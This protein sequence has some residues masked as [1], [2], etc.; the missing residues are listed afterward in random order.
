MSVLASSGWLRIAVV[1]L[2]APYLALVSLPGDW[3]WLQW[4]AYVPALLVVLHA[5]PREL[6]LLSWLFGAVSLM[7]LFRW[8]APT[9]TIYLDIA[10][11]YSTAV[12]VA[13]GTFCGLPHAVLWSAAPWLRRRFG[14]EWMWLWPAWFVV[15]ELVSSFVVPLPFHQGMTQYRAGPI[16]QL[17]SVTGTA[18]L[19][20]LLALVNAVVA[21]GLHRR[22][23]GR[24]WPLLGSIGALTTVLVVASLGAIRHRHVETRLQAAETLR[25]G[26]LQ[27]RPTM[28]ERRQQPPDSPFVEWM[29][30][31]RA[32]P[33]GTELAV[34]PEGAS[35]YSL[36]HPNGGPTRA[37][38]M[39]GEIARTRNLELLVGT[40]ARGFTNSGELATFNAVQHV[41]RDGEL[42]DRYDKLKLVPFTEYWPFGDGL[43]GLA[44]WLDIDKA[45]LKHGTRPVVF[46]GSSARMAAP[47]CYESLLPGLFREFEGAE[48]FVV[49]TNDGWFLDSAATHQHAM[50]AAVRAIELGRPI[51]H[52]AY[53][54]VSFVVEP[55][56]VI[57]HETAP[58]TEVS[59]AVDVRLAT[60]DTL[61]GQWGDWFA[62]ACLVGL[63]F[64]MVSHA[65]SRSDS[66]G[67]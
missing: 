45:S 53:T 56:G 4:V 22:S 57:L 6:V 54:G 51:I 20:F 59:R 16:W 48:L 21:E 5:P 38:R 52:A 10:P 26:Q 47:V 31:T 19:T 3:F 55:H 29:E 17:A 25:Y 40:I 12:L 7:W 37:G 23:Q 44:E 13:Y 67:R 39:V 18:G 65:P 58:F 28:L 42:G 49:V 63:V 36:V 64:R 32:L 27:T 9:L 8:I 60:F 15:V 50:H 43:V 46:E 66:D 41:T 34:W 30:L 33:R 35:T 61:Y 62:L 24:P 11:V 2:T 1:L 14:G